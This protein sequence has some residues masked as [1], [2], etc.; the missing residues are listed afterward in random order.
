MKN[1]LKINKLSFYTK[2]LICIMVFV[3]A[4]IIGVQAQVI[5]SFVQRTSAATPT[6]KIYNIKGDYVMIGN[7][8]LTLQ[9]YGNNTNNSNNTMVYVDVDG[10]PNTLNSSTST[11][12]FSTENGADPSCSNI[13]YAGLYWTG[14]ASNDATS[15]E[16]FTVTKGGVT[17]NFNKRTVSLKGPGAAGYTNFVANPGNIYYPN[18]T[19]GSMYS[20]YVEVTSYVKDHGIG[21]Y[22]VADIALV[23][24]N[25]GSTGYYGGWGLIVVYENSKMNWRDVTVFDGHA[26]VVGNSS[27]NFELPV[28]GFNTAQSGPINMKLGVMAGEGDVG[29]SGDYFRIRNW[30]DNAWVTLSHSGNS[31]NNFFNGSVNTGGNAR[32]PN[33]QNNTGLDIAMFNISNPGNTVVTNSQTS[34][35]FQYGSTQDTYIIFCIAM[36]VDA[37]IPDVELVVSTEYIDGV[38]VGAAPYIAQPGQE[39]EYKLEVKNLGTEPVDSTKFVIPLP[40]TVSYVPASLNTQINFTPS[41]T[42]N[43]AYFDPLLGPTG[44]IVWDFGTLPLPPLGFPDSVLAEL[45][46]KF[47]VTSDCNIL[48]N[49]DCPPN[50]VLSGGTISGTGAISGSSFNNMPFIQGYQ[51]SGG[52]IGEPITDPLVVEIDA[53]TFIADSCQ[54]TP[55]N[56]SL[57]FCNYTQATIPVSAV[58]PNFPTGLRFFNT[59][60]ITPTSIEYDENNPFPALP[61]THTYYAIP[62]GLDLCYYTFTI[63]VSNLLTTPTANNVVYCLN[64]VASPLMATPSDTS[65]TLHYY[66]SL[67]ST[68]SYDSIVPSTSVAGVTTYYVAEAEPISL[69][70]CISPNKVPIVVSVY[71]MGAS[72]SSQT[73]VFCKGDS[74]GSATV[75]VTGGTGNYSY[76]W[77]TNPI[78]NTP[79]AIN[80]PV[81][82]Y[83]V[84]VIDSNGC[85]VPINV[86]VAISEP[87]DSLKIDSI[88]MQQVSCLGGNDGELN[89]FVNG[90]TP[91]Y[92]YS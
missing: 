57:A 63:S 23:E 9:S 6:K 53:A 18:G 21:Q 43:N 92:Q 20:G 77:N 81:G 19:Y 76:Q 69:G 52:C 80:L 2:Q 68:T 59:N 31:T 73:N 65:Y 89:I 10:D 82:N 17:K 30:Q 61:G 71:D 37:Y 36:A 24:G 55:D 83:T 79:T 13:I 22:S 51:T 39:I 46:F 49:P 33:L 29:I 5:K 1:K 34:T 38:P 26:Y 44:S 11:L 12:S 45:T 41:P 35:R 56:R 58:S 90:G 88:L 66:T 40:Y 75:N 27:V 64:E 78:Q 74:T 85:T 16:N 25:G 91:N 70:G 47:K 72:I 86:L 7:T 60:N 4:N 54:S 28:S 62:V 50:V 8:N 14:R 32:N 42:P 87:T 48:K 15:P 3:F 67:S 84:T